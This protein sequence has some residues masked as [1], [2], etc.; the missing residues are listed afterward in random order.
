MKSNSHVL[1]IIFITILM[2]AC[3]AFAPQKF[4]ILTITEGEGIE[5]H[6]LNDT[7]AQERPAIHGDKVVWQETISEGGST[8]WEIFLYN[9]S[10]DTDGDTIPNYLE[11]E[12][13]YPDP[14]KIRITY[15]PGDQLFPQIYDNLIVWED[16]RNVSNWD[17]YLYNLTVDTDNDNVPNYID[18]DDDGDDVPDL[19]DEDEDPAE[20]RITHNPAHQTN[21][22]VYGSK[23]VWEDLRKGDRDIYMYDLITETEVCIVGV[24][25]K[26]SIS[27]YRPLQYNP[28][29]HGDK[30]TYENMSG[31][32]GNVDIYMY[33]LSVDSD[34]DGIPNWCDE[35]RPESDPAETKVIDHP[36][37]DN[38]NAIYG[39]MIA[40]V[41][42]KNVYVYDLIEE[43]EYKL[44]NNTDWRIDKAISIYGTKIVWGF[45][46]D[47]KDSIFM[48]DLALDTDDDGTPNYR[49]E[50]DDG[51]DIPDSQDSDPD[52]ALIQITDEPKNQENPKIYANKIVWQDYRNTSHTD[53]YMH[54]L[55][56][57]YPPVIEIIIPQGNSTI[58]EGEYILFN[59]TASDPDEDPLTYKWYKNEIILQGESSNVYNFSTDYE[60]SGV[61]EIKVVVS[62]WEHPIEHIWLVQ[63][64][65]QTPPDDEEE[66]LPPIITSATPPSY[67]VSIIEASSQTFSITATDL[68]SPELTIQWYMNNTAIS[69]EDTA[70]YT[71]NSLFDY[72]GSTYYKSYNIT[73]KVSDEEFSIF[74]TWIFNVTYLE[75]FDGDGYNDS[76]EVLYDGDP[77]DSSNTPADMDEDGEPDAIDDDIDGD[78]V[79]ND[80][81]EFPLDPE[82]WRDEKKDEWEDIYTII[83]GI[84]MI[85][86]IVF[87][88]LIV[89]ASRR[90]SEASLPS[91]K[92]ESEDEWEEELEEGERSVETKKDIEEAEEE[93]EEAND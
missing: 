10:E 18:T 57:N 60:S 49:D 83:I 56:S 41:R 82:R 22:A 88:V 63:V 53:I 85:I 54:E 73:V 51:D 81:D 87:I 32:G 89:R 44:T 39:D 62:D 20:I 5:I 35:D 11:N 64:I 19:E 3:L 52:P 42:N 4:T 75:D 68:D 71:F 24:H 79:P 36:N 8:N 46:I 74:H 59:I 37:D 47:R 34:G 2:L 21:P 30:I 40:F 86:L 27:K 12:R 26:G 90:R 16:Q 14:A 38:Y 45:D 31:F 93:S 72:N 23:I 66:N 28:R 50:D 70:H 7:H 78:G 65:N 55:I 61:Y 33:N 58:N 29:I 1:N 80:E 92:E 84:L 6:L 67:Y 76:L 77:F 69:G 91:S 25:E 13:P 48:Y 17:I 15:D 9:L 43:N